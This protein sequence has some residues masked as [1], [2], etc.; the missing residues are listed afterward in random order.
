[1]YEH[2]WFALLACQLNIT[3]GIYFLEERVFFKKLH[4]P[5]N[6]FRDA[7][8]LHLLCWLFNQKEWKEKEKE[9]EDESCILSPKI[10]FLWE[11]RLTASYSLLQS[12]T[13]PKN[14]NIVAEG[15]LHLCFRHDSYY[16]TASKLT[17]AKSLASCLTIHNYTAPHLQ[18]EGF[19][20]PAAAPCLCHLQYYT[21]LLPLDHKHRVWTV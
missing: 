10:S 8:K 19:H 12:V 14:E 21:S 13:I 5:Y 4:T 7:T 2:A 17:S 20:A 15:V 11:R 6:V 3:A 1:M 9:F 18:L 16:P